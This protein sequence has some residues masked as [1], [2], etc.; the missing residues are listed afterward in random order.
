MRRTA[1][2]ERRLAIAYQI[3]A[4]AV[5]NMIINDPGPMHLGD[6]RLTG[7]LADAMLSYFTLNGALRAAKE[8]HR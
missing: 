8:S 2:S 1:A 5:M 4:G 3:A 6:K 7:E